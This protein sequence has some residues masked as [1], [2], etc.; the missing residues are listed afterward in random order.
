VSAS[1]NVSERHAGTLQGILLLLPI[2]MAVMGVVVLSPVL[3]R[4]Q[5]HFRA[6]PGAEY[7]VPVA[8]TVPALCI[9]L[10]SP[11]AGAL[12]D[13]FG[14][15]RTLIAAL[16]L[17]AAIGLLPLVLDDLTAIIFSRVLLGAMEAAIVTAST[18]LIGDYFHGSEREKWLAYQTAL[19]S[20]SAVVLFAIGGAL[21][22]ISWRAPFAVYSSSLLFAL[23]LV[24]WTWE[25]KGSEQAAAESGADVRFPWK[26][27]LPL[28]L[29]AAF[30]GIM[31]FTVQIQLG[32]LLTNY[33]AI[34]SPGTIGLFTAIGSLSVPVGALAYRRMARLPLATQLLLSFGLI[35]VSFVLMN[36]APT[37][38]LIMVY[39]VIN[40]FG[41]G[42]LLPTLVVF[43]MGRL[44]FAI[45]GR[46]TGL[47]MTGWWIGQFLSP[48]IIT[49]VGKRVGGLPPALQ[50]LG[51]LCLVAAAVATLAT[52]R[53]RAQ[54][55]EPAH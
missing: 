50:A 47:F 4:M 44:P 32:Y 41:A 6:L 51:V 46:G 21:G 48:Q 7:L 20:A 45:R 35:G 10:L 9:A 3:P 42:I 28:C 55:V 43:T 26:T 18:T 33:Y 12:V 36:H 1:P 53:R 5:E 11:F 54:A 52:L 27:M 23:A 25:P 29:L 2:T 37:A 49:V 34:R 24:I 17:Y 8:L 30:G 22:N 39:V 40:Q 14:R 13:F 19:A 31:F 38:T 16:F 15:R